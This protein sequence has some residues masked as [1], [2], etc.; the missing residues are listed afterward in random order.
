MLYGGSDLRGIINDFDK[1]S[2]IRAR[3]LL[4]ALINALEELILYVIP[5]ANML[6]AHAN[7]DHSITY[8]LKL[9]R[10]LLFHSLSNIFGHSQHKVTPMYHQNL[11][12]CLSHYG[13]DKG[14][15]L[16]TQKLITCPLIRTYYSNL[17]GI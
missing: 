2:I 6:N 7:L 10:C 14:L 3:E 15:I 13:I 9:H 1:C 17:E 11:N 8:P 12:N 5:H 4:R 16:K